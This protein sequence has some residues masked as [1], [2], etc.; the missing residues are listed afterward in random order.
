MIS[1]SVEQVVADYI[2]QKFMPDRKPDELTDSTP[3]IS[4]GIIDSLGVLNLVTFLEERFNI[5]LE[6]YEISVANLNTLADI[7]RLVHSKL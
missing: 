1:Q 6:A 5:H 3:L 2:L 7:V 4:G